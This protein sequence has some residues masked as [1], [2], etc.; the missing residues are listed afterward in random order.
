MAGEME[1]PRCH[2]WEVRGDWEAVV[3]GDVYDDG[4][5]RGD[6]DT[7]MADIYGRIEEEGASNFYTCHDCGHQ[8]GA[9]LDKL[10]RRRE[11][12]AE[13]RE[14]AEAADRAAEGSSND[15]EIEALQEVMRLALELA[16]LG[17]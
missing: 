13:I 6:L 1:C 2:S 14:A 5:L 16:A 17:L 11:L 12:V 15:D 7:E 9:Q 10:N 4:T 8:W 3:C